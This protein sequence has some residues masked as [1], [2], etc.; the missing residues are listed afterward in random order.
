MNE[1]NKLLLL[2]GAA[3]FAWYLLS[4]IISWILCER[5]GVKPQDY[6]SD[7]VKDLRMSL[8]FLPLIIA[9]LIVAYAW[10]QAQMFGYRIHAWPKPADHFT[11]YIP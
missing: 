4:E 8:F 11:E 6:E 9:S 1:F 2:C 10:W 3:L 7:A 5:I